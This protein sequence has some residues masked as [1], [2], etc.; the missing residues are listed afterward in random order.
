M[1][2]GKY[3]GRKFSDIPQKHLRWASHQDFD[4]DLLYSLRLE[5]KK[6]KKGESFADAANP[7]KQILDI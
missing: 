2:L 6:R 3:R 1:P 7:F 5:L 4:Q